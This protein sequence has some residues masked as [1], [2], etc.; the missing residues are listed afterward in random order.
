MFECVCFSL[1]VHMYVCMLLQEC[2]CMLG[3]IYTCVCDMYACEF[4]QSL[5]GDSTEVWKAAQTDETKNI[6][7]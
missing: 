4:V 1:Y 6:A 5:T 3:K 7:N 2:M